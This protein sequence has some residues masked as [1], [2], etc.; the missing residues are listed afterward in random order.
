MCFGPYP[1]MKDFQEGSD[2]TRFA[3]PRRLIWLHFA[4]HGLE[5]T[6]IDA[7]RTDRMLLLYQIG[8]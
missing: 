4:L 8:K 5:Q 3:F 1:R 7:W 2:I 6:R